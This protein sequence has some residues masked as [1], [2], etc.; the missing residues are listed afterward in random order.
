[1]E[2]IF[3][4]FFFRFRNPLILNELKINNINKKKRKKLIINIC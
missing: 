1:M 2:N 4:F 3:F